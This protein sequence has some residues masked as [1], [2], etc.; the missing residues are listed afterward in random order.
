MYGLL[1]SWSWPSCDVECRFRSR[2]SRW[3][4]QEGQMDLL[5]SRR[6]SARDVISMA[7]ALHIYE[8]TATRYIQDVVAKMVN[9]FDSAG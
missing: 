3:R 8:K 2:S 7:C 5:R 4:R 9:K 6:G 1:R